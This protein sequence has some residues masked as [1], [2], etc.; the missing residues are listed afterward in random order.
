M[1]NNIDDYR[2]EQIVISFSKFSFCFRSCK[3]NDFTNYLSSD[4]EFHQYLKIMTTKVIPHLSQYTFNQLLSK[5]ERHTHPIDE[6]H[7]NKTINVIKKLIEIEKGID[8]NFDRFYD[9]NINDYSIWQLGTSYGV[10]LICTQYKNIFNVLFIDYHHLIYPNINYN[11]RDFNIYR[12]CP[13]DYEGGD[14]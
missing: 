14:E 3:T 10:R 7:R 6:S 9:D 4:L 1:A 12:F 13:I 2:N 5:V 11:D 8:F